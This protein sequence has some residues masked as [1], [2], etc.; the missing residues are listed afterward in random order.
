M[1]TRVKTTGVALASAAAALLLAGC[2]SMPGMSGGS[3]KASTAKVHCYGVNSC[4][5]KTACATASNKCKGMN[6]CKGMGWLPMSASECASK[7]GEV[8]G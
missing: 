4:K 6:S 3:A 1:N 5:G 2:D 8:K 7:G